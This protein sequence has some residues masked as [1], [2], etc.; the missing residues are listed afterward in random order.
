[1]GWHTASGSNKVDA[2]LKLLNTLESRGL[3][4]LPAKAAIGC[5]PRKQPPANNKVV[6]DQEPVEGK[7]ADIGPIEVRVVIDKQE[8][9]VFNEYLHRYHYLG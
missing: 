3:I 8:T 2:C 5:R 6:F 4:Q 7:L 9:A 1:L